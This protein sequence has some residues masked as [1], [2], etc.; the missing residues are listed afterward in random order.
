MQTNSVH[1]C[2][3]LG[4]Q[5]TEPISPGTAKCFTICS[6]CQRWRDKLNVSVA[7]FFLQ[8]AWQNRDEEK[9]Y[10][11]A[12]KQTKVAGRRKQTKES[13]VEQ[14]CLVNCAWIISMGLNESD[15]SSILDSSEESPSPFLLL[16]S[17]SQSFT[18]PFFSF[19]SIFCMLDTTAV[20]SSMWQTFAPSL[21]YL[22]AFLNWFMFFYMVFVFL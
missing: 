19:N 16:L 14:V 10:I 18:E 2:L 20:S 7:W 9:E 22:F 6:R 5:I 13:E 21:M 11:S 1:K 15:E 8:L 3:Q 17:T 4:S 12:R